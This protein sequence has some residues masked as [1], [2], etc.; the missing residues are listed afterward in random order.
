[1]PQR[2]GEDVMYVIFPFI[3]WDMQTSITRAYYDIN[4]YRIECFFLENA[5]M[6]SNFLSFP[7]IKMAQAV[8]ITPP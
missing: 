2:M 4:R 1:M 7:I 8:K 6:R 5:K 3:G